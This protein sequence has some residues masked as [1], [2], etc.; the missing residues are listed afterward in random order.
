MAVSSLQGFVEIF[1]SRDTTPFVHW[2]QDYDVKKT[3]A[4]IFNFDDDENRERST[5]LLNAVFASNKYLRP[6]LRGSTS[7][8]FMYQC[9]V[10]S[11][12][13][14]IKCLKLFDQNASTL[15]TLN[16]VNF[17]HLM[18][19]IYYKPLL[20]KYM[21]SDKSV[22][23]P[24]FLGIFSNI[25]EDNFCYGELWLILIY[26]LPFWKGKH[27]RFAMKNGIEQTIVLL[28]GKYLNTYGKDLWRA[29]E[30]MKRKRNFLDVDLYHE[31]TTVTVANLQRYF[32]R[33]YQYCSKRGKLDLYDSFSRSMHY[34]FTDLASKQKDSWCRKM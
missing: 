9:I 6:L 13:R 22:W 11:R 29:Y 34:K 2:E 33:F 18:M 19:S 30:C 24:L 32:I 20:I 14:F 31:S 1:A 5:F 28:A 10:I 15:K 27:Y 8:V 3:S 26:I 23:K 21:L 16:R 4:I 17:W 7:F 25:R 12:E